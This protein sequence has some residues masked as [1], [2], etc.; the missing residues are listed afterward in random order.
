MDATAIG[1][2]WTM[3]DVSLDALF[4]TILGS[5]GIHDDGSLVKFHANFTHC[6]PKIGG[7]SI[8]ID[9]QKQQFRLTLYEFV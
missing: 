7:K 3:E 6:L 1:I 5:A 9:R 4:S 2:S 8:G